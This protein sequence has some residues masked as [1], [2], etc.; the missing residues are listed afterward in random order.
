MFTSLL[1]H[2]AFVRKSK[3]HQQV[4]VQLL[5][6]HSSMFGTKVKVFDKLETDMF[7]GGY[8]YHQHWDTIRDI[9][10][11]KSNAYLLHMSWTE[12]KD[13]KLKFFRQMVCHTCNIIM[14]VLCNILLHQTLNIL[15]FLARFLQGEWYLQDHCISNDFKGEEVTVGSLI[16]HCCSA[17]PIFSCHFRDKPS[18]KPCWDSPC[19][20]KRCRS[21]WQPTEDQ[22]EEMKAKRKALS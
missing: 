3:S 1:Y 11:G 19:I 17:E 6:E 15:F 22:I 10:D 8:H 13:N 2:G 18:R 14:V 16:S 12:N 7:P 20:D 9:V 5:L 4:L 21:F